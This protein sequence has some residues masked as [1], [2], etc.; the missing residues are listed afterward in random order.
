VTNIIADDNNPKLLTP[1]YRYLEILNFEG[2][3]LNTLYYYY[4]YDT[5]YSINGN[6]CTILITDIY[7]DLNRTES[8]VFAPLTTVLNVLHKNKLD[9]SEIDNK[10][11]KFHRWV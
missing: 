11:E 1:R 7:P 8:T 10:L 2:S 9:D 5:Q 4:Y 6:H 3:T